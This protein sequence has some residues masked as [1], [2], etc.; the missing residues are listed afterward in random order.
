MN[1]VC[2]GRIEWEMLTN[3]SNLGLHPCPASGDDA[4]DGT[5]GRSLLALF[6]G[7]QTPCETGYSVLSPLP[8][9][10]FALERV[11]W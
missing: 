9:K 2:I 3:Y 8:G 4:D 11:Y 5:A 6:E 1:Q 10:S 7:A